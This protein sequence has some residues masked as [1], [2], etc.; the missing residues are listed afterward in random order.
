M[1]YPRTP[2]DVVAEEPTAK[3]GGE[4]EAYKPP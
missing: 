2:V 4:A 3:K 1:G